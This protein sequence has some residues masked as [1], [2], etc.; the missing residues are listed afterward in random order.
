MA[1]W[2]EEEL[3]KKERGEKYDPHAEEIDPETL[4]EDELELWNAW[5]ESRLSRETLENYEKRKKS[6]QR[7]EAFIINRFGAVQLEEFRRRKK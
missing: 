6:R 4:F 5:K 3:R 1:A 7:L 2:K